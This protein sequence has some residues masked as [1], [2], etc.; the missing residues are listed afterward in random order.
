M[1]SP[2]TVSYLATAQETLY[3]LFL[4]VLHEIATDIVTFLPRIVL[5]V[6]VLALT[7]ALLKLL[8]KA[9]LKAL[10]IVGFDD[11]FKKLAQTE[12]PFSINSL[13]VALADAGV[14]LVALF[15]IAD[16]FLEPQGT[17]LLREALGYGA[18]VVSVIAAVIFTFVIF[19]VL[20]VRVRIESRMRGYVIFILLILI[21]AMILD[22]TALSDS[23]KQALENGLSLGLGIAVGVFAVWF[24]FHDYLDEYLKMKKD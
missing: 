19:S 6:I 4:Q 18:R 11:L 1:S 10:K 5:A 13:I 8:N 22:L 17:A 20:I 14:I 9:L 3:D 7:F 2:I 23:T 12:L 21:T 16:L 24:F 15:S